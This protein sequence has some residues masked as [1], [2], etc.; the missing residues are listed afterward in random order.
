MRE[1]T[2]QVSE[3]EEAC[4]LVQ[5]KDL[6]KTIA[7][8]SIISIKTEIVKYLRFRV[9]HKDSSFFKIIQNPDYSGHFFHQMAFCLFKIYLFFTGILSV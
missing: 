9:F 4:D 3:L 2:D 5:F 7:K 6:F 1:I 8:V